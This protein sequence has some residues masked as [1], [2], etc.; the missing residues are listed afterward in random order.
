MVWMNACCTIYHICWCMLNHV[1]MNQGWS[2]ASS[3]LWAWLSLRSLAFGH[4][5]TISKHI[6]PIQ[7]RFQIKMLPMCCRQQDPLEELGAAPPVNNSDGA[8]PLA[9]KRRCLG[10]T[11]LSEKCFAWWEDSG[12]FTITWNNFI[13]YL[14]IL[15]PILQTDQRPA[16]QRLLSLGWRPTSSSK[17]RCAKSSP[18]TAS[19]WCRDGSTGSKAV[20][21]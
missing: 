4:P 12:R 13:Q 5:G 3:L 1:Q 10:E 15:Q 20:W 6:Q 9:L 11:D 7:Y 2:L 16:F 8:V 18:R 21:P 14:Y 19:A 17:R